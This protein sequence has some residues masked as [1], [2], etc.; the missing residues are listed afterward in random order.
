[1]AEPRAEF[2]RRV[3]EVTDA[4]G[5]FATDVDGF[6]YYLPSNSG[7][8]NSDALRILADELDRRNAAWERHLGEELPRLNARID[9]L[10]ALYT[11]AAKAMDQVD[12]AA[13]YAK[14]EVLNQ[15][16]AAGRLARLIQ[17]GGDDYD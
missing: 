15:I 2:I 12:A 6:V 7:H 5:E 17:F 9:D 16:H 11:R 10:E 8:L 1:M 4:R 13:D 14:L 3:I